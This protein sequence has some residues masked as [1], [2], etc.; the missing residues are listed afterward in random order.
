MNALAEGN[1]TIV[2]DVSGVIDLRS[3]SAARPDYNVVITNSNITIAGETAPAGGITIVGAGIHIN[4]ASDI[5]LRHLRVRVGDGDR[6]PDVAHRDA[7]SVRRSENVLIQNVSLSWSLDELG[8]KVTPGEQTEVQFMLRG[9][10][11][12]DL[13]LRLR[14]DPDGLRWQIAP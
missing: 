8:L 2:F 6:G 9:D 12:A 7:L 11:Q 1:R 5:T 13:A 3:T 10:L 4:D 14:E